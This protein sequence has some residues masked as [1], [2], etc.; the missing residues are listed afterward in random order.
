QQGEN[1]LPEGRR[2]S[3]LTMLL[4][5]FADFM[6]M[7]LLAAALVS[8]VIGEP[9]DTIAILVIVILNA[10]IGTVQEFRAE[11]AVA[12]LR[13]MAAP[14]AR[15]LRDGLV[16]SLSASQLVTGDVV[17]LEAGNIVP[18]DLRLLEV[19]ALQVDESALSGES[20]PVTKQQAVIAEPERVLGDRLNLAFKN[21]I[22]T[23]GRGRGVV[24][25]T[26]TA[27]EI[28]QIA[29]ILETEIAVKT[30]LQK[31]LARFGRYLALAVLV[32]CGIV[33]IAGLLQGQPMLL[34]FL[35]AVSL[36]VA[37]IPE[38]LPAVVT[39]SLAF[40]ARKLIQHHAL[41]RNLPAVE[42]LGSVT[43]I[44]TDKT[45]TLTQNRMTAE[46][47]VAD[48]ERRPHFSI[49]DDSPWKE[50]GQALALNN[51]VITSAS[52]ASGEPTELALFEA[53][54]AAGFDKQRLEQQMPRQA[55]ISFDSE[56]KQMTTLHQQAGSVMA[57][58]KGAPEKILH[59][60]TSR[61]STK[62]RTPFDVDTL[63]AEAEQLAMEGY[64]VLAFAQREF[65]QM[66]GAIDAE[67]IEQQ[68][69]F[70]GLVALIDPPR[71]EAAQAVADCITAGITPVMITGDHAGTAIAI[72]RRLGISDDDKSVVTGEQLAGLS[73]EEFA[74][75][76]ES[77]AVYARVSPQQKIRIVRALQQNNEFVAMTGDGVNDAPALKR[78]GIGIA[79][80]QKGTDVAREA[81][82]MVLLDDNFAT[83]VRAVAAGRRIF[84]NIRKFI[85]YT[86][87]SNAGEI[88]TLFLAPF[89]GLPIPLLP[90]HILWINLVTDGLP[91]L[92]F[93]AEPAEPGIMQR[94]PR[95]PQESIF[96]HGM[97]QYI[98]WVGLFIGGLSIAA[99]AWAISREVSYWQTMVFTV[100]TLSQLFHSL[101]VRSET[102]S[103]FSIGLFS[104]RPMLLAVSFTI[105]LQMAVIYLPALNVVFHTQPLPLLDLML[106]LM[107]SSLVLVVV[108]LNKWRMQKGHI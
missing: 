73:D 77:I 96:A 25:A 35:T 60:C 50:L 47:F 40:G 44:C 83:I 76:V 82:D 1:A 91:G 59:Q 66:P 70:I 100:L 75:R 17:L 12:A 31:R 11:R 62:A 108:E 105:L 87:S 24:I 39:I 19:E 28:G 37:A 106:C 30:P 64:R 21:T 72:A 51:D 20:Q 86:M 15:V 68:L 81:A 56:R 22:I 67:S 84:D 58:V 61:L 23:R 8:G 29:N 107:L 93:T 57:Y 63:L 42:T 7:V 52:Q 41:V 79:M 54:K 101:A 69:C 32:I 43:Y 103:L 46:Q 14:E 102:E 98:I 65:E 55:V 53:A 3:V 36:A 92:A 80:G 26:G 34:M 13:K 104:N 71:A 90:I 48:D 78:A 9:Q 4:G 2:R 97:W 45:G 89:L 49:A 99:Q 33:F 94:P 74:R 38:A 85:K 16:V 95:P 5:Q 27:T 6:I 88:W 18:A 10:I